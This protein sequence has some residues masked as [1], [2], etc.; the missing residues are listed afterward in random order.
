M[1][2]VVLQSGRLHHPTRCSRGYVLHHQQR[3]SKYR[4]S[5]CT[6]QP[7]VV[8]HDPLPSS[9]RTPGTVFRVARGGLLQRAFLGFRWAGSHLLFFFFFFFFVHPSV[10]AKWFPPFSVNFFFFVLSHICNHSFASPRIF[11][12]L[13]AAN[14]TG[15]KR[16]FDESRPEI[17]GHK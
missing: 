14:L 8:I 11:F 6:Q 3:T 13:S 7:N 16:K 12:F 5:V 1:I 17:A 15:N 9:R 10:R 4:S 2:T